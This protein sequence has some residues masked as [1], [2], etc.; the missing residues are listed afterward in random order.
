MVS[1]ILITFFCSLL[2]NILI[3]SQSDFD[4]NCAVLFLTYYIKNSGTCSYLN[5]N[6]IAN[7]IS[8]YFKDFF[9][10]NLKQKIG[11]TPALK[12]TRLNLI[13]RK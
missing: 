5:Y 3:Y 13:P 11:N 9:S 8:L 6:P 1:Q 2:Q 12:L 4:Q 10:N 7:L